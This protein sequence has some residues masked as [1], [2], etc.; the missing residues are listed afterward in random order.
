MT[1]PAPNVGPRMRYLRERAGLSLRALAE[2]CGLS[3]NAISMIE[4]GE[5]SPKVSSLH[6]LANALNVRITDFFDNPDERAT[7]FVRKNGRSLVRADQVTIESAGSGLAGQQLEPFVISINPGD[8][9]GEHMS[10]DRMRDD[11]MEHPGQEFVY[12]LDG[13]VTYHVAGRD[14]V[15]EAGDSLLFHATQPHSF[16]NPG[17][18][19]ARLLVV[20]QAPEGT[21]V[22]RDRHLRM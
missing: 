22:G 7:V 11:H 9:G 20:L 18:E 8:A 19:P 10:G 16:H 21:E 5:T 6:T 3:V 1:H 12:C 15:L 4:R 2:A 14:Y 13:R 17:T